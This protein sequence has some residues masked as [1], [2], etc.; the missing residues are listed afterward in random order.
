M[1]HGSKNVEFRSFELAFPPNDG[2]WKIEQVSFC[3]HADNGLS[4][5]WN[6]KFAF[7]VRNP[8]LAL[9][10]FSVQDENLA[11]DNHFIG[12][13][14]YPVCLTLCIEL[15][16]HIHIL[17]YELYNAKKL[18]WQ[19]K[20]SNNF[21]MTQFLMWNSKLLGLTHSSEIL[22]HGNTL[23]YQFINMY[24][25]FQVR[26]LRQGYRSV[27][28]LNGFGEELLS[29]LLVRLTIEEEE[30]QR[31]GK[32]LGS[33][34]H[35][36]LLNTLSLST[37]YEM[38]ASNRCIMPYA[39]WFWLHKTHFAVPLSDRRQNQDSVSFLFIIPKDNLRF[40]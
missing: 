6:E 11:D 30:W 7:E 1:L 26:C 2:L 14:T 39:L 37:T 22:L 36:L 18:D 35:I 33:F 3:A 27:P 31:L 24:N 10:R 38:I 28:L 8:D 9:I 13:A 17:F 20:L 32:F 19:A 12:Q 4:P 23:H 40:P 15:E 21:E 5:Y 29:A 25:D 16:F 34:R